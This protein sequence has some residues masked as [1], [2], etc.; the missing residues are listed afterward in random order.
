MQELTDLTAAEVK[1]FRASLKLSQVEFAALLHVSRPGVE[2]WEKQ[3][4]PG[5]WR[6][7][8]TAINAGLKPWGMTP[9][10]EWTI[11]PIENGVLTVRR[12]I[13]GGRESG[14]TWGSREEAIWW[15]ENK[16]N[17]KPSGDDTWTEYA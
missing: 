5:Y 6:Y 13:E 12:E 9:V 7:V 15:L 11:R 16:N 4:A 14:E 1:A 17:A 8:F 3:G 10:A 2:K